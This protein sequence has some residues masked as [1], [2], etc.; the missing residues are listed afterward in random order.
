MDVSMYES[1]DA[2]VEGFNC[3][4]NTLRFLMIKINHQPFQFGM[5]LKF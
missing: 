4:L 1:M 3:C 2:W 5:G